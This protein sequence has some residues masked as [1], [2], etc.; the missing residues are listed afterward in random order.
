MKEEL[1]IIERLEMNPKVLEKLK[2]IEDIRLY[3]ENGVFN[4]TKFLDDNNIFIYKSKTMN[5]DIRKMI[6]K[7]KNFKQFV[8]ENISNDTLPIKKIS[9]VFHVGEMD[10]KNKSK[11]SLEGSGL[12]V[13][14]N[15][16]EWRKI[17]Q[18]GDREL[19][20]LTNTNGVFVDGNKLNKQQKN[21]VISW[22]LENDYIS[23][24]ETYKVCWYDDEMEDDVCMEFPTYDEAKEEAGDEE[25]GKT[26]EVNKSGVLPTSKL[27]SSS[28]Q[29]R[30]EPSQTFDLLLTIFVEKT[31]NYDG[32]WWNDKLDVMKYSAPRGVIFN[33]KLNNWKISKQ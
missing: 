30:I 14:I 24:K 26:I 10:I 33:S 17:A 8:N 2:T 29:G 15:P 11:F 19:Y 18:L 28:M 21:N 12:S 9:K 1:D 31:T 25:D 5:E 23:Q 16:D 3:L 13:S 4:M 6:D 22:G 27:I 20:L 7:V 32:I